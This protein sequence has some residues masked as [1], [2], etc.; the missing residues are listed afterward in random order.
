V[1]RLPRGSRSALADHAVVR[2]C[3]NIN[4]PNSIDAARDA[5]ALT[6]NG[7]KLKKRSE[8]VKQGLSRCYRQRFKMARRHSR[9]ATAPCDRRRIFHRL[10]SMLRNGGRWH[11]DIAAAVTVLFA[12]SFK[13]SF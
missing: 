11:S 12:P 7:A 13:A 1:F 8:P 6:I 4:R 2:F 9:S 10:R 5:R 3:E